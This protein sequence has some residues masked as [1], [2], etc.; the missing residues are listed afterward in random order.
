MNTLK[1]YRFIL[2][3]LDCAS[4][5]KKIETHIASYNEYKDVIVN[6]STSTLSFKTDKKINQGKIYQKELLWEEM[7]YIRDLY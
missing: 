1:N 4:C 5:A 2:K 7:I 3:D 6:F